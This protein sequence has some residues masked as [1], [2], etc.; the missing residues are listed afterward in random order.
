M[1]KGQ[2]CQAKKKKPTI[3]ESMVELSKSKELRAMATKVICY[4]ICIELTEVLWK[5][6]LRKRYTNKSDYMAYMANFSQI[7]GITAF[8]LQIAASSIIRNLGWMA[9]ALI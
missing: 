7:V 8:I 2:K 6:I 5:G 3:A 1:K 9:A 4:N